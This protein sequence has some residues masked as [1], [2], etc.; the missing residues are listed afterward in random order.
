VRALFAKN[1]ARFAR[2]EQ[3][4]CEVTVETGMTDWPDAV[5]AGWTVALITGYCVR[6]II[7]VIIHYFTAGKTKVA[8]AVYYRMLFFTRDRVR[9]TQS[10][11]PRRQNS[12]HRPYP[13]F[14]HS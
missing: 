12:H 3:L 10:Q 14:R 5:Y 13:T 1:K 4:W 7:S 2:A 11:Q 6:R 9:D 8:S